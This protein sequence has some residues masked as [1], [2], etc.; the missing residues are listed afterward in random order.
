MTAS[1]ELCG[2]DGTAYVEANASVSGLASADEKM[3]KVMNEAYDGLYGLAFQQIWT[4]YRNA[5]YPVLTPDA[6][7]TGGLNPSGG[8]P[9]RWLYP[10][11]ENQLNADAW[12]AAIAAQGADL[13]DTEVWAFK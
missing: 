6:N 5:G 12:S 13:L 7:G 11:S 3:E 1:M 8:I 4:N 10:S 9:R 2:V